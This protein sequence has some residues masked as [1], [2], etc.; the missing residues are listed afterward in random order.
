MLKWCSYCQQFMGEIHPYHDLSMTHGLCDDCLLE[1]P[2][3][4][5]ESELKHPIFLRDIF[6]A[7]FE[8]GQKSD[9]DTA[10]KIV[11]K[12][13]DA[14]CRPLDILVGMI[15][16][17][18]YEIGEGWE[19]GVLSVEEEHSFTAFCEQVVDLIERKMLAHKPLLSPPA[20]GPTALMMNAPGN[21]HTLALRML[22]L[23]LRNKGVKV[24]M[25]DAQDVLTTSIFDAQPDFLLISM[26][27]PEQLDDVSAIV[28][29]V[30]EL[31]TG[32]TQRIIVGGYAIKADLVSS[33][34]GAELMKD[35]T[36]LK[37]D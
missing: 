4:F 25:T 33:I 20:S 34:P 18:L 16:P 31:P 36:T 1:H 37:I 32:V 2:D 8:A 17:M 13:I 26:A 30:N 35:I 6:H 11:E 24:R 22:A 7:L 12:A 19:Q 15:A 29:S 3:V 21:E 28:H 27:L 14:N 5:A 10:A 23:W 9:I